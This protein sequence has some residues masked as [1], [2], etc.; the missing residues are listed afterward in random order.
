MNATAD[1]ELTIHRHELQGYAVDFHYSDNDPYNQS[2]VRLGAD[3]AAYALFDFNVLEE[4][5]SLG[6]WKA[7][8]EHLTENLFASEPLRTALAQA[9]ALAGQSG[10]GLRLRLS[11]HP[12]AAELNALRWET[13]LDPQTGVCFSTDQNIYFSRYLASMDWRPVR[14]RAKR[15]LKA[16]ALV[17]A[18][19]GL[20]GY[21]LAS[22]DKAAEVA[23]IQVGLGQIPLHVLE[24]ATLNDLFA[25]LQSGEYDI[26]HLV[27][28]GT[29][30]NGES[31][32]WLENTQGGIERVA[33]AELLTRMRELDHRPCLVVLASCQSAGRG[34]GDVLASLGP[35]L[36]A[37]GIPAVLAM[38]DNLT[39]ETNTRLMPV[40]LEELQKDGQID[41]ALAV[42]RAQVRER[43]DWWVPAL[44]MR[45][46]SGRLWYTPGFGG[47]RG[48]FEKW[49]SL[50]RGIQSGRCT[51]IL[52]PGLNDPLMGSLRDLVQSWADELSYPLAA[53]ERESLPQVAQYRAVDQSRFTAEEEWL[54]HLRLA[55][56]K[57]NPDLPPDVNTPRTPL[58]HL[59]EAARQARLPGDAFE[60]YKILAQ[61][62]SR[63]FITVNT[64][65]LLE[66]A[67]REAGKQP[68]TMVCPWREFSEKTDPAMYSPDDDFE[69]SAERPL[70]YHLFGLLSQP[71][72]LVLTEDD[73]FAY[74][75]GVTRHMKNIPSQVGRALADSALLFLGF[76][77][78]DWN[79]RVVMQSLLSKEGNNLLRRHAHI[80][81]QIEP[82]EA[83][84]IDPA[85]ARRYLE[86][87]FGRGSEIE[88]NIFWGT[89]R[90]FLKELALRLP[91]P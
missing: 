83:R 8:G 21:K 27:A 29:F 79:F 81:A 52:G 4:M 89:A 67:L 65:E 90:E 1:I 82:D 44:F 78:E 14:L 87:Y 75:I 10:S 35:R 58:H 55:L 74:L 66:A 42:A 72:S 84:L 85:R 22:V 48:E 34:R 70:V 63:V 43:H 61:V 41:R 30:S 20:E 46:K 57:H 32:L 11:I 13:L 71:E 17:A 37:A 5:A 36:A 76:Q 7:Y 33:G 45:L 51:P 64:D 25:A 86:T 88:I 18:P 73:T 56:L 15:E 3:Q 9:R 12:S 80:A 68:S 6:T 59:L 69:P 50:L 19:S 40:F 24:R 77:S 62:P 39:M 23:T 26:L 16:L 47:P 31:L 53:H 49:P 2:E 91:R 60:T 54:A 38:Q 28:H